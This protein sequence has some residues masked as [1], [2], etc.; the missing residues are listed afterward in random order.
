MSPSATIQ[1]TSFN[2]Y[3]G[4]KVLADTIYMKSIPVLPQILS[5]CETHLLNALP[6][7]RIWI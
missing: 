7:S 6:R 3:W 2:N 1:A 4:K 5:S